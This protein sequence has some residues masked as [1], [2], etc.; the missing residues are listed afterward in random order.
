MCT[1]TRNKQNGGVTIVGVINY[2][3][4]ADVTSIASLL[5]LGFKSKEYV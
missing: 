4:E 3:I 1:Y 5:G 2:E